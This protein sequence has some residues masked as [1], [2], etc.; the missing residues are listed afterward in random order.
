LAVHIPSSWRRGNENLN[1]LNK[2]FPK[3][4]IAKAVA[5]FLFNRT[6]ESTEEREM[7]E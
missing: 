6:I 3:P 2:D 1:D 5:G 7:Y 4:A